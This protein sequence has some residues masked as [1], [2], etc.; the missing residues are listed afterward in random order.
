MDWR[1]LCEKAQEMGYC[2]EGYAEDV[3]YQYEPIQ[4]GLHFHQFGKITYGVKVIV[5]D[6]TP[7]QM[8]QIME[9]LR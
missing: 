4:T 3:L 1:E 8:Y 7:D 2:L 9:A 6:R 5:E